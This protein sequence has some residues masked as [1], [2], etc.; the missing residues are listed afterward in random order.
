M[1]ITICLRMADGRALRIPGR[2]GQTLMQAAVAA[3]VHEIAA[4]CGGLLSCAT[5]HVY[6]DA[7][8]LERL[9]APSTDETAMLELTAAPREPDSRL[10]CQIMLHVELDGLAVRL[11]AR[12]Y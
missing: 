7:P 1:N 2:R 9:A 3:G 10:S 8:W 6:V 11:P 5:C 12:Q 4:D